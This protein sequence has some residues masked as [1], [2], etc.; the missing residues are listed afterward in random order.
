MTTTNTKKAEDNKPEFSLKSSIKTCL[1]PTVITMAVLWCLIRSGI[2]IYDHTS[3]IVQF[4]FDFLQMITFQ[5]SAIN[6]VIGVVYSLLVILIYSIC[7]ASSYK[8]FKSKTHCVIYFFI[9]G[10]LYCLSVLSL[11][12]STSPAE[13]L[14]LIQSWMIVISY[15][16]I[17]GPIVVAFLLVLTGAAGHL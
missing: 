1:A 13:S 6:I 10:L 9:L 4:Y 2:F 12:C 11:Y 8:I 5:L 16:P 15:I 14:S 7:C 3:N 17:I